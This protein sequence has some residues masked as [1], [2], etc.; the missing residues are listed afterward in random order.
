MVT[1]CSACGG[2]AES[3]AVKCPSCGT[4][5]TGGTASMPVVTGEDRSAALT[6]VGPT[7]DPSLVIVKGP[8]AGER[9][10]L[11]RAQVAIGR[12]PDAVIFLNDVT[13]S[14]QHAVVTVAGSQVSIVDRGS[15]NGTYVNGA[16]VEEATLSDGDHVQIGRFVLVF[17]T[18]VGG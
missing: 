16:I 12:D 4:Q 6:E 7:A 2:E 9:F 5:L 8:D 13:V 10:V 11:D 15:L 3:G 18:G 14:R 17:F 1:T